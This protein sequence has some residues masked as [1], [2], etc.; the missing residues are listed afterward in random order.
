LE[1]ADVLKIIALT[2]VAG[3]V[4]LP[5]FIALQPSDF[6]IERSATIQAPPSL[7][8]AHIQSPRAMNEWSPFA[9]GDPQMKIAYAGPEGGVGAS[10]SW[11]SAK[12]GKGRMTVSDVKPDQEVE[13]KLEFM[14]PMEAT[15]RARFSLVPEGEVTR[16]TWRMEGHNG[17]VAK[18]FTLVMNMDKMVGGEFEK[19]L[20]SMKTLAEGEQRAGSVAAGTAQ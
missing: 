11:D 6:A 8:Y 3:L 18:A 15:N 10:S 16:V 20:A 14:A 13:M 9:Q 17:F 2:L 4:I 19:G 5:A 7:I 12:L 1:G